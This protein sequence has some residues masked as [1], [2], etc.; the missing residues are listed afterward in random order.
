M[1]RIRRIW[2]ELLGHQTET[3]DTVAS[4]NRVS[5]DPATLIRLKNLELRARSVVEGFM[6]G[7]HRSPW[8]G[9]SVEFTDYRQYSPGD[10]IRYLD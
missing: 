6:A 4:R 3:D 2:N 5:V 9:F 1:V 8:H 10:D 7:I